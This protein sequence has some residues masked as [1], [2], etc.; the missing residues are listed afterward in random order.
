MKVPL[1]SICIP[2]YNRSA[3]LKET[4]LSVIR[5]ID[6]LDVW[7]IEICISD[8]ASTDGTDVLIKEIE[9]STPVRIV[10]K[11]NEHNMGADANYLCS[12]DIASGDYC[13]FLGSD[14]V[15]V[16]GSLQTILHEIKQK[17]DIY[18]FNRIDCNINLKPLCKRFWLSKLISEE[19]FDFAD[20]ADFK[21]YTNLS[22]SL[23]SLF[24]YLSSIVFK[25]QKWKAI[26]IDPDFMGTAYSHVYM[27]MSFLKTGCVLKYNAA[28]LVFSRGD[29][30][31]FLD[32]GSDGAIRRIMI[33]ING[34]LLLSEKLFHD[35]IE[36]FNG[37]LRVVR[38]ERPVLRTLVSLRL[39]T[40]RPTW[41]MVAGQFHRCGYPL[42]VI[43][44]IGLTKPM[45]VAAK[46]IRK[47]VFG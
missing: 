15:A 14:D 22:N 30:D 43:S 2:T 10:Y 19:E 4:I 36:H 6:K 21:R 25:R 13:W 33:D 46:G 32:P 23:G 20:P 29:N 16:P 38:A 28:H 1:L 8:N 18:L 7:M 45:L 24:S 40:D 27:L 9:K 34:Y 26:Q 3:Y 42:Y 11:R 12:V 44:L 5:Q 37:V 41:E 47:I 31:S 35:S 17:R 39:R